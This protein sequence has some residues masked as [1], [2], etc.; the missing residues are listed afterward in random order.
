MGRLGCEYTSS[1]DLFISEGI[2]SGIKHDRE[3]QPQNCRQITPN[4]LSNTEE[5]EPEHNPYA[6]KFHTLKHK[7]GKSLLFHRTEKEWRIYN[8]QGRREE[9]T[10]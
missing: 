4:P 6:A 3:F 5:L 9:F 8:K 2:H 1:L 7:G 10:M